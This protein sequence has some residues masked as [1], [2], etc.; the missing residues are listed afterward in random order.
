VRVAIVLAVLEPGGTQLG[1]LRVIRALR[2]QGIEAQVIA[3]HATRNG[4]ELYAAERI[5]V[6]VYGSGPGAQYA[7]DP[8]FSRWL[9]PRLARAD[10]VHAHMFGAW[11]AA[12]RALR[13]STPLVASEHNAVR[14]PGPPCLREMRRALERVNLF[15]AHGPAARS[16]VLELGYPEDALRPGISPV[17]GFATPPRRGLPSPRVVFAGRLEHEKGPDILLDAL[18]RLPR[19]PPAFLLGAGSRAE[20]LREQTVRLGLRDAVRFTGWRRHPARWIA[21]AAAC[22]VPSRHEAWSQT[23]VL[24]MGLG[25]PV[26][27]TRVEGLP[28]VL[29]HN[30]GLLVPEEEPAALARMLDAVLGGRVVPD[31]RAAREYAHRFAPERVAPHYIGA[32]RELVAERRRPLLRAA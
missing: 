6:E 4:L 12:G 28:S 27:G 17:A 8:D 24:A 5:S 1:I 31:L 16:L 7:C 20:E 21:G 26:I 2:R 18:A 19:P 29:G 25:V 11:W 10:V 22:V 23:A 15:Y 32:Y 30:R 3:A 9:R 13:R 14:W